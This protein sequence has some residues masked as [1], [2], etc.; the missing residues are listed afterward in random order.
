M[1]VPRL[2]HSLGF[3]LTLTL[4][5]RSASAAA[6]LEL[7]PS[8]PMLLLNMVVLLVLIVPVNR[9][10]LQPIV[11]VLQERE[12]RTSGAL[13]RAEQVGAESVESADRLEETLASARA[14]G[15][16]VRGEI[17]A[18]SEEEERAILTR[19]RESAARS[20]EAVRGSISEELEQARGALREDASALAREAA[21]RLL[22]R[23][24]A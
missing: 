9:L 15:Q 20:V 14:E 13:E 1:D 6:G 19:A 2:L 22:G 11:R 18:R 23:N 8:L 7:Y 24:L 5:P 12:A 16:R 17:M 21:T 3:G 4:L 10:L